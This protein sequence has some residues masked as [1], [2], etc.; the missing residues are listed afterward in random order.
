MT[1]LSDVFTMNVKL[2][3][4]YFLL[5]FVKNDKYNEFNLLVYNMV[6]VYYEVIVR[7]YLHFCLNMFCELITGIS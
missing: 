1:Y 3:N 4:T 5:Q 2:Y 6:I 7:F